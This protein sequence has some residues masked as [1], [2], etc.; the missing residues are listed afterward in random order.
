MSP[1]SPGGGGSGGGARA[2]RLALRVLGRT[3]D[4]VKGGHRSRGEQPID[5]GWVVV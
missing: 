1:V 2:P 3:L 4:A 5:D